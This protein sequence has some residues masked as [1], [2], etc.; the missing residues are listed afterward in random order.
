MPPPNGTQ[1]VTRSDRCRQRFASLQGDAA[2]PLREAGILLAG[3]NTMFHP[4][5]VAR[6]APAFHVVFL[7]EQ[8]RGWVEMNGKREV[9][10]PGECWILPAGKPHRYGIEKEPWKLFWFHL[11]EHETWRHLNARSHS[12]P[13]E[14]QAQQHF[15]M[16]LDGYI[17]ESACDHPGAHQ[18]AAA[19]A[20]L[21]AYSLRRLLAPKG[22]SRE[23]LLQEAMDRLWIEVQRD[24]S[25]PW[26]IA[27]MAARIHVSAPHFHRLVVKRHGMPPGK[28]LQQF[29]MERAR[30]LVAHPDYTLDADAD[31]VGYQSGYALSRAFKQWYGQAPAH[32]RQAGAG[33]TSSLTR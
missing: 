33:H 28:V 30:E 14:E 29:R 24:L 9:A 23:S 3:F 17:R 21:V 10:Q 19:Y 15:A 2:F 1:T 22:G 4:W 18:A 11:T 31:L 32:Y 7:T 16:L 25:R 13:M 12:I 8:G 20:Q 26:E 27:E 5:E 6:S